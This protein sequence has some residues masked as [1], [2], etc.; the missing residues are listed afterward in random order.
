AAAVA[1]AAVKPAV[2]PAASAPGAPTVKLPQ[3]QVLPQQPAPEASSSTPKAAVEP[4]E[5]APQNTIIWDALAAVSCLA[6]GTAVF[7]LAKAADLL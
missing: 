2:N 3:T 5:A 4:L 7:F 6:V 1:P